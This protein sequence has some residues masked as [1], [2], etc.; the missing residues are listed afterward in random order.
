VTPE[1]VYI[2]AWRKEKERIFPK[3]ARE[4]ISS[5]QSFGLLLSSVVYAWGPGDGFI[6][7]K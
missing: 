1:G 6:S 2:Q 7:V 5:I 4:S 3:R